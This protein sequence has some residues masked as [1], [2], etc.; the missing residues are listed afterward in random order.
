MTIGKISISKDNNKNLHLNQMNDKIKFLK[1]FIER[2]FV[3]LF[4][5][6]LSL[7]S[8]ILIFKTSNEPILDVLSG[9]FV[10]RL[11][12]RFSFANTLVYDS[13]HRQVFLSLEYE[14]ASHEN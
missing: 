7:T 10:D 14:K 12:Q 4:L 6:F 3:E 5:W 8:L 9:S 2:R 1:F 11:L 13:V